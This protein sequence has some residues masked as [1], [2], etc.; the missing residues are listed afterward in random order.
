M[1]DTSRTDGT[2]DDFRR[3]LGRVFVDQFARNTPSFGGGGPGYY[4]VSL[5]R[6]AADGS[7]LDLIL[8]FR[9]GERY[10][11]SALGCHC[12]IRS[13]WCWSELR[14]GMDTHGLGGLSLPTIRIVRVVVEEGATFDPGGLRIPLKSKGL[15]Y[16]DGPFTPVIEPNDGA[17]P[18]AP[19]DG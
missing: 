17:I 5:G 14:E 12:D 1:I 6:V 16:E 7:E 19:I 9:T 11:C 2:G 18:P 13:A 10:C 15:V 4:G 8:T 3:R